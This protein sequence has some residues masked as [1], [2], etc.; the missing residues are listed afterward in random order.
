M[1][2][3]FQG[4]M[5]KTTYLTEEDSRMQR[6]YLKAEFFVQQVKTSCTIAKDQ[7]EMLIRRARSGDLLG[8]ERQYAK[9]MGK[10]WKE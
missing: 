2:R 3:G 1:I 10:E 9:I 4:R 6:N 5:H 8:A 7:K